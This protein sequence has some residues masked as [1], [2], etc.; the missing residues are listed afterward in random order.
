MDPRR[1][2]EASPRTRLE[3]VG[4]TRMPCSHTACPAS[5]LLHAQA[6][7]EAQSC[8]GSGA[9]QAGHSLLAHYPGADT[10]AHRGDVTGDADPVDLSWA[11]LRVHLVQSRAGRDGNAKGRERKDRARPLRR[12]RQSG[13]PDLRQ[14]GSLLRGCSLTCAT[15]N[16]NSLRVSARLGA[17]GAPEWRGPGSD[18]AADKDKEEEQD[19]HPGNCQNRCL[20]GLAG[21]LNV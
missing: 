10:E 15:R 14:A 1:T 8:P 11:T 4:G 13:L 7:P 12:R 5:H 20:R 16:S 21:P 3:C 9:R 17:D 18:A 19:G 6:T 2:P